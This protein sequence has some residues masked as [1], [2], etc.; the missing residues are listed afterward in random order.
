MPVKQRGQGQERLGQPVRGKLIGT[1]ER[2][3]PRDRAG[4]RRC[5][6]RIG[7]LLPPADE[8]VTVVVARH[9]GAGDHRAGLSQRG[10]LQ[11][12]NADQVNRAEPLARVGDQPL[13]QVAEGLARVE[14]PD[15]QDLHAVRDGCGVGAGHQNPAGRAGRP[16][17]VQVR[18]IGQVVEY[19]QPWTAGLAQPGDKLGGDRL[20]TARL[21]PAGRGGHR[22]GVARQHRGPARGLDPD[23]Q[24]QLARRATATRRRPRR[25]GTCPTIS[26]SPAQ[27][28]RD[29]PPDLGPPPGPGPA[30]PR[31]RR[32]A[33]PPGREPSPAGHCNRRPAPGPSPIGPARTAR[34]PPRPPG[35]SAALR[36][37]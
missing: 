1:L 5:A 28:G 37:P 16:E 3:R 32:A 20:A 11:A 31:I 23:Q 15:R 10:R 35:P 24:V 34:H 36:W 19:H 26:A 2:D 8:V 9:R 21:V 17:A 25:A 30:R 12:D 18:R 13:H 7:E 14:Q 33:R 22:R 6:R 4:R 27:R 29:R